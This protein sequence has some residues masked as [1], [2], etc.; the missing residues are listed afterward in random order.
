M[1]CD[2]YLL[3]GLKYYKPVVLKVGKHLT[4]QE[5][6][7][8]NEWV[9]E[10]KR[11]VRNFSKLYDRYFESI[12]GFVYR[13]TEDEQRASDITSQTFL[14]ALQNLNKYE[15][16]GLPFSAWLFRIAANEVNKH[17][18]KSGRTKI[19]SIEEERI[20]DFVEV[21]TENDI[22]D[23]IAKMLKILSES[24]TEVIEILE[25]RFF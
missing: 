5:I 7:E 20:K 25:L 19:F 3:L 2:F 14:K 6:L 4:E 10:A 11:D 17:Y 8:E 24:S 16:R 13:R 23:K 1:A 12:F 18:R 15:Y 22:D 21:T 9:K